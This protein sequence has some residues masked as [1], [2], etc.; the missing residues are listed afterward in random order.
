MAET[1]YHLGLAL[2]ERV[3]SALDEFRFG[4]IDHRQ[5][6]TLVDE[7]FGKYRAALK[8]ASVASRN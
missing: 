5:K 2:R 6:Q 3:E 7:A 8:V 4:R 1:S